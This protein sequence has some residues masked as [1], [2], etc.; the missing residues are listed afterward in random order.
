MSDLI[1][2]LLFVAIAFFLLGF[3]FSIL[4]KIG[5]VVLGAMGVVYLYNSLFGEKNNY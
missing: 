1:K 5:I 3:I 4:F 2:L